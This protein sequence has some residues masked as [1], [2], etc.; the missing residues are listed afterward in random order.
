MKIESPAWLTRFIVTDNQIDENEEYQETGDITVF[1]ED[2]LG[3][4]YSY[5]Q[6]SPL[7]LSGYDKF[8]NIEFEQAS[9]KNS[10]INHNNNIIIIKNN[11]DNDA[12]EITL[13]SF[14]KCNFG[15]SHNQINLIYPN[16]MFLINLLYNDR[17]DNDYGFIEIGFNDF[18]I[19][20][21]KTVEMTGG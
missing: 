13:K 8:D 4:V 11:S 12:L 21:I 14:K 18:S 2:L 7:K 1:L 6:I 10:I 16:E 19:A 9:P 3:D 20:K 17:F 5:T 15:F